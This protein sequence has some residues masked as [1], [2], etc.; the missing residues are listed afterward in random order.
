[1]KSNIFSRTFFIIPTF[2][3]IVTIGFVSYVYLNYIDETIQTGEAYGFKIGD[4]K[5][6]TFCRTKNAF[7]SKPVYILFPLEENGYGPHRE[8]SFTK[9]NFDIL[10]KREEWEFF[11]DDSFFDSLKLNFENGKLSTIHRYRKNF[12]LP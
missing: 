4:N 7:D 9:E 2:F 5:D 11:F 12:E 1:M 10:S 8:F 3:A 6:E